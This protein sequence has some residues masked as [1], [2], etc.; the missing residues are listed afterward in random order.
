MHPIVLSIVCVSI[1]VYATKVV[2][3]VPTKRKA[4][5]VAVDIEQVGLHT[6]EHRR[7]SVCRLYIIAHIAYCV[8]DSHLRTVPS[9]V[10]CASAR[11]PS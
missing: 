7:L 5:V 11:H 9:Y 10:V 6:F 1:A 8:I 2:R 4:E 3:K